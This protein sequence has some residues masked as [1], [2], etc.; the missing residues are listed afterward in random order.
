MSWAIL[1]VQ[2]S[3]N[4]LRMFPTKLRQCATTPSCQVSKP[5]YG[6]STEM[7]VLTAVINT[8]VRYYLLHT[9]MNLIQYSNICTSI[10]SNN[11]T[12]IVE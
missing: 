11:D 7:H 5:F 1:I 8:V 6:I 3:E 4:L 12:K 9:L 10:I 2:M